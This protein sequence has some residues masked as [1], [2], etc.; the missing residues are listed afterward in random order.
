LEYNCHSVAHRLASSPTTTAQ[1]VAAEESMSKAHAHDDTVEIELTRATS[2][3]HAALAGLDE[4]KRKQVMQ[5]VEFSI[6]EAV[7]QT[8][9]WAN[10]HFDEFDHDLSVAASGVL[11]AMAKAK[12]EPAVLGRVLGAFLIIGLQPSITGALEA[13]RADQGPRAEAALADHLARVQ[14]TFGAGAGRQRSR[15]SARKTKTPATGAKARRAK[16]AKR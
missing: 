13:R 1:Q 12:D 7:E 15:K 14:K 3:V 11:V 6:N 9:E 4:R 2:K 16:A 5:A 10:D 8:L